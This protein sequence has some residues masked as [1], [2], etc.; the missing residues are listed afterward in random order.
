MSCGTPVCNRYLS[1]SVAW[2]S[3]ANLSEKDEYLIAS[4]RL[5]VIA[6]AHADNNTPARKQANS[7][8][9]PRYHDGVNDGFESS[10]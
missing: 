10:S 7:T 6:L 5:E 4:A 8:T 3:L 9:I 2:Q 1:Q